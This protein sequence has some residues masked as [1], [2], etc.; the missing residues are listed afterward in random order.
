MYVIGLTGGIASGK[1][2]VARLL[3][4]LGAP[5]VD[6]DA[7]AREAVR[8]GEPAWQAIVG[9][10]G[11]RVLLPGGALDR[12]KVGEIIFGDPAEK[13]WLDA[14]M[15]PILRARAAAALEA[16][17]G[18]G[19][20]AAVLDVPLLYEAGWQTLADEVWVV[21]VDR[22]TQL[23]RLMRRNRLKRAQALARVASQMDLAEKARRADFVVDN[24]G[25][26]AAA[27]TQVERRWRELEGKWER[28]PRDF[29]G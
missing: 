29:D 5:V 3:G 22:E 18:R 15:H 8:Q 26:F 24:N 27:K 20:R 6:A 10:Y 25:D 17:R 1:S 13:A 21:Y 14:A 11:A 7:L 9:R 4:E 19:A 12:A 23:Q 2:T 16:M 28:E